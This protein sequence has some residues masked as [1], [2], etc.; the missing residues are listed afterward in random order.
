V[1]VWDY[2]LLKSLILGIVVHTYNS[3][4]QEAE[5]RGSRVQGQPK[6]QDS[7][8]K[9]KKKIKFTLK[10]YGPGV[11]FVGSN[12]ISAIDMEL[13]MYL[14]CVNFGILCFSR[15]LSTLG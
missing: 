11:F 3:S 8:S 12:C 10:L 14:S 15:N 1:F 7:V 13:L 5:A 4:T 9:E 6:V 2:L